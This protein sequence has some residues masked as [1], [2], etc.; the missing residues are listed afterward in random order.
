MGVLSVGDQFP[1]VREVVAVTAVNPR[2]PGLSCDP[3]AD[4]AS[5][6][7]QGPKALVTEMERRKVLVF[8]AR[9]DCAQRPVV[10]PLH[11]PVLGIRWEYQWDFLGGREEE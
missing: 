3:I 4:F 2:V 10:P 1:S 7:C 9:W 5:C 11:N 8:S 6:T